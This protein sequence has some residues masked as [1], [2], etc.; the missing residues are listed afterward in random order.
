MPSAQLFEI[1]FPNE[2]THMYKCY[3]RI[4][5]RCSW[6]I[7]AV[8]LNFFHCEFNNSQISVLCNQSNLKSSKTVKLR[9]DQKTIS[10]Q[11]FTSTTSR[12]F[13]I[14]IYILSTT[15][16][17]VD[18]LRMV[19][20]YPMHCNVLVY[21]IELM[22]GEKWDLSQLFFALT[23]SMRVYERRARCM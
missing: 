7:Y 22:N 8:V 14:A 11:N 12:S 23:L 1:N 18:V 15:L 9:Q 13:D 20:S 6:Y 19:Q 21:Q 17:Q 16:N 4:K 3:A 5:E 10:E 2:G